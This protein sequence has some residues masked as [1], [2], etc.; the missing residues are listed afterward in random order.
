M[1]PNGNGFDMVRLVA[2]SNVGA[3][4]I[5]QMYDEAENSALQSPQSRMRVSKI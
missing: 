1:Y 2:A 3:H 4:S 5:N